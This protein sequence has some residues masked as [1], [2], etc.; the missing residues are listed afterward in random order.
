MIK[1]FILT[2]TEKGRTL[3]DVLAANIKAANNDAS[4][5]VSRVSSLW[6]HMRD[7]FQTGNVLIFI[8]AAGIAVRAIAPY[9]ESKTTDPAVLVI[10]EAGQYV[11]PILSGHIGGANRRAREIA[12]Y[13]DASAVITTATDLSNVFSVDTFASE[14]GY[15]VINPEAIKHISAA[16]LDGRPA[17]L[18]SE[19]EI[20][21]SLPPLLV[22]CDGIALSDDHATGCRN[23]EN[24][25]SGAAQSSLQ[26][27][28][29]NTQFPKA[30]ICIGTDIS[31]KPFDI[32]LNLVPKCFHAGIGARKNADAGLLDLFFL[33]MLK[34]LSIPLQAVAS[35][36][37][38]ELKK[39]EKALLALS[40]KYR[41]P[42]KTYSAE[43]L[44]KVAGN[45]SK[46][47]FVK[48]TTGTGNVCE[49]AAYL[50]SKDGTMV[51]HKT[52]RNGA[53]LAIAREAWSVR[54]TGSRSTSYRSSPSPYQ[55]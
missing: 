8:G 41:I 42:F 52:A 46:S 12:G 7:V 55:P 3:A 17:G 43:E 51:L 19:F 23:E 1:F 47:D 44:C 26:Q 16:M 50:A 21:G 2:F 45:F 28:A 33:E 35:I 30:G 54:F 11:I 20:E 9:I 32:T 25:D 18:W 31:K 6:E 5:I 53:T 38:I 27:S 15:A 22:R 24:H 49:A 4:V 36:S 40:Q 10:D 37:S 13:I 48:E 39:D 14:L 34:E 29:D